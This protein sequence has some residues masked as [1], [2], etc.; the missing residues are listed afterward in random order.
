MATK[1]K[2]D[3]IPI[4]MDYKVITDVFVDDDTFLSHFIKYFGKRSTEIKLTYF[5]PLYSDDVEFLLHTS[6]G[7]I[8]NEL[9]RYREDWD[10]LKKEVG[11]K[12]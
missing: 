6:K 8:D 12:R 5:D 9:I 11:V 3:V 4:A 7:L 1:I 2:A 10:N